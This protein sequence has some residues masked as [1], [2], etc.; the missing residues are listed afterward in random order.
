M[1]DGLPDLFEVEDLVEHTAGVDKLEVVE[2]GPKGYIY[3]H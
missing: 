1:G 3:S 2:E